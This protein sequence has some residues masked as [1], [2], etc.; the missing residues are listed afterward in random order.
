LKFGRS[1]ATRILRHADNRHQVAPVRNKRAAI[2]ETRRVGRRAR[3]PAR[4]KADLLRVLRNAH[5]PKM[6]AANV[7]QIALSLQS[8]VIG[9]QIRIH[10]L[11]NLLR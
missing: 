3:L 7:P 1:S 2:A 10:L 9:R 6:G 4:L 8:V 11:Q 5:A